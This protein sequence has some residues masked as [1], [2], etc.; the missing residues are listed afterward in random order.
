VLLLDFFHV[1]VA[2]CE[3]LQRRNV[4][5]G[6]GLEARHTVQ[7][8][9]ATRTVMVTVNAELTL[10]LTTVLVMISTTSRVLVPLLVCHRAHRLRH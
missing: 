2:R 1:A 5:A 9:R 8:L 4:H 7:S 6:H 3:L 10:V